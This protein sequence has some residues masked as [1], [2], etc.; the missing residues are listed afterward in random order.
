MGWRARRVG[1]IY[2]RAC[3][4]HSGVSPHG[5]QGVGGRRE[6]ASGLGGGICGS[7]GLWLVVEQDG[8]GVRLFCL[9]CSARSLCVSIAAAFLRVWRDG[10]SMRRA[11]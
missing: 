8:V 7:E 5:T 9:S 2:G 1:Q 10:M 3:A 4:G 6:D 11:K